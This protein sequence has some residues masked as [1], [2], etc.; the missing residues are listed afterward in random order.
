MLFFLL[1]DVVAVGVVQQLCCFPAL[2]QHSGELLPILLKGCTD[3]V[4][5][6]RFVAAQFLAEVVSAGTVPADRVISEIRYA[7]GAC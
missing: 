7:C 4:A 5:N 2:A 3:T 1:T 6:V